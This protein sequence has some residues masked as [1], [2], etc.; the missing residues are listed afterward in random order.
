[1]DHLRRDVADRYRNLFV[2][3][4]LEEMVGLPIERQGN[5]HVYNQFVIRVPAWLRDALRDYLTARKIGL[6]IY[7]PIPLHLQVC[8]SSLGI[9]PATSHTPRRPPAKPSPCPFTRS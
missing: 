6:E 7:Y 3:H 5:Y 4:G 9:N 8:F 1:M 2:S